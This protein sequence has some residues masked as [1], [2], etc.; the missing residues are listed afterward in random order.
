MIIFIGTNYS[1]DMALKYR[2]ESD[3]QRIKALFRAKAKYEATAPAN[4]AF[5]QALYDRLVAFLP[6]YDLRLQQRGSARSAQTAA[7]AAIRPQRRKMELY[8]SHFIMGLNNAIE[9][10][11]LAKA[12]RGYYQLK[13]GKRSRPLLNTD[14]RLKQ[15]AD[16]II[17]GEAKRVAAGGVPL[18][19]PS[20]AQ[21]EA[22]LNLFIPL[23][24]ELTTRKDAYDGAQEAVAALWAEADDIIA[25]VWDEVLFHFRKDPAPSR[26]RKAREWGVVYLPTKG[27]C[28]SPDE[29][30]AVGSVITASGHRAL[31]N[32][33][34]MVIETDARS[35][36]DRK[37][38]FLIGLLPP[39]SY[40]IRFS[41]AGYITKEVELETVAGKVIDLRMELE[42]VG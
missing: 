6:E 32:V 31:A 35:H 40:T 9:R 4:R 36:S 3:R 33:D 17:A 25:D 38:L 26:R 16:N 29:F 2:P 24:Q 11:E 28:F 20:A 14:A 10:E 39:G 18:S 5:S 42:K 15:W 19:N 23:I 34:V 8:V 30:S 13:T 37:G 1:S 27:E 22:Q 7:T 21:V 41:L 12:D